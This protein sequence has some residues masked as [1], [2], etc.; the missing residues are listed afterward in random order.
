[1]KVNGMKRART[2]G[3][4]FSV[5]DATAL[6]IF[7]AVAAGLHW[8]NSPLWWVVA[9]AASHFFLFCTLFR[10][11]RTLELI[12][13][14]FF[15]LNVALWFWLDRLDWFNVIACQLPVSVGVIAWQI[16]SPH[17]HGI[18]ANHLNSRLNDYLE[19]RTG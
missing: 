9:I 8:L 19:G 4:R 11:L 14:T 6:A 2:W 12:W 13:A 5:I 16:K 15:I 1:M 17:Y 18:F 7:G 3:F 10:V